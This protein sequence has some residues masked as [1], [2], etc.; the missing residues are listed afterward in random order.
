[1]ESL[2]IKRKGSEPNGKIRS[3]TEDNRMAR[4][5]KALNVAERLETERKGSERNR[6]KG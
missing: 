4:N 2:G 6:K 5:G 3:R 1:M